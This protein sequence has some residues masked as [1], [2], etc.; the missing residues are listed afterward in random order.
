MSP[1]FSAELIAALANRVR[2][3]NEA[4]PNNR[5]KLTDLKKRFSH[6]YHG[7]SEDER[8]AAAWANVD[9]HLGKLA[10]VF[11]E[12]KH[13]RGKGGKFSGSKAPIAMA[14]PTTTAAHRRLQRTNP[15]YAALTSDIVPEGRNEVRGFWLRNALGTAAGA[16]LVLPLIRRGAG[17][18]AGTKIIQAGKLLGR[19]SVSIPAA[20]VTY[21]AAGAAERVVRPIARA[22]GKP[23][24]PGSF[25]RAAGVFTRGVGSVGEKAGHGLGW[26]AAHGAHIILQGIDHAAGDHPNPVV[27]RLR[28]AGVRAG[29]SF[30]AGA[31]LTAPM[32]GTPLDPEQ[33]GAG[34]DAF[35][36]RTIQKLA[37]GDGVADL[38]AKYAPSD[39][40]QKRGFYAQI[41][42]RLFPAAA[43]TA[44]GLGAA[45]AAEGAHA[46]LGTRHGDPYRDSRGR[47]ASRAN[48]VTVGAGIAGA[49][50]GGA[51][52]YLALKHG[53]IRALSQAVQRSAGRVDQKLAVARSDLGTGHVADMIAEHRALE[54]KLKTGRPAA[55]AEHMA[56]DPE[57]LA[58]ARRL[59]L[60]AGSHDQH[61]KEQLRREVNGRLANTLSQINEFR[62]PGPGKP[63]QWPTI[64]QVRAQAGGA[65]GKADQVARDAVLKAVD[66]ASP[67]EFESAIAEMTPTQQETARHWMRTR[68]TSIDAVDDQLAAH[69]KKLE[70]LDGKVK[71]AETGLETA[72]RGVSDAKAVLDRAGN[73]AE[74]AAAGGAYTKAQEAETAAAGAV[75]KVQK[76]LDTH[77]AKPS[78]V[79]SPVTGQPVPPATQ[80]EL[81]PLHIKARNEAEGRAGKK[82][83]ASIKKQLGASK[84]TVEAARAKQIA[85]F[86]GRGHRL[87]AAQA[88]LGR[89]NNVIPEH[90]VGASKRVIV[91]ARM[92][93]D[94]HDRE[95]DALRHV[96]LSRQLL[97]SLK[98]AQR[99]KIPKGLNAEEAAALVLK[100]HLVGGEVAGAEAYHRIA[101]A[102]AALAE[103]RLGKHAVAFRDRIM[104]QPEAKPGRMPKL[105]YRALL[106]DVDRASAGGRD[107]VHAFLRS[108]VGNAIRHVA[109]AGAEHVG[110][111]ADSVYHAGRDVARALTMRETA[112]GSGKYVIDPKKLL[113]GSPLAYVAGEA[114]RD[115][116]RYGRDQVAHQLGYDKGEPRSKFPRTIKIEKHVDPKTGGGFVGLSVPDPDGDKNERVLLWG[117]HYKDAMAAG[118]PLHIGARVSAVRSKVQEQQGKGDGGGGNR[119]AQVGDIP[120]LSQDTKN[121]VRG[122][123]NELRDRSHTIQV[124]EGHQVRFRP[125]GDS[126]KDKIG[127][128]VQQHIEKQ[129][130]ANGSPSNAERYYGALGSIV[131]SYQSPILKTKQAY[132]LLTGYAT[133]GQKANHAGVFHTGK[134]SDF[135]EQNA[136]QAQVKDELHA[137]V[138]RVMSAHPPRDDTQRTNLVRA[139]ALVGKQKGVADSDLKDLYTKIRG[140]APVGGDTPPEPA[141]KRLFPESIGVDANG[142]KAPWD[143][144]ALRET[145]IGP[146]NSLAMTLRMDN[147][148]DPT[149]IAT[150]LEAYAHIL[151]RTHGLPMKESVRAASNAIHDI[152]R[153]GSKQSAREAIKNVD[154]SHFASVLD[155]HAGKEL[156]DLERRRGVQKLHIDDL[157]AMVKG[158]L[159][160]A[161]DAIT[162]EARIPGGEDGGGEWTGGGSAGARLAREGVEEG[163][164]R[165]SRPKENTGP[166]TASNY[167]PT[168]VASDAGGFIVGEAGAYG[169]GQLVSNVLSRFFPEEAGG[170]KLIGAVR[171]AFSSGGLPAAA[172]TV[173]AQGAKA[174][175]K[176]LGSSVGG[177]T[178]FA[179]GSVVGQGAARA[180]YRVGG[181]KAPPNAPPQLSTGEQ[182]VE[183]LG[184][185]A[186]GIIGGGLG[187]GAGGVGT[188]AA[189]AVGGYA[190]GAIGRNIYDAASSISQYFDGHDSGQAGRALNR[191]LTPRAAPAGAAAPQTPTKQP[192]PP[193]QPQGDPGIPP[194]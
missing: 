28:H 55:I 4:T 36:Y 139:V 94:A 63:S 20:T 156:D 142:S 7:A 168:R 44:A 35:S 42:R 72:K 97:A 134:D 194:I 50:A 52:A 58:E 184:S 157:P 183:T 56:K 91:A 12:G 120:G 84:A 79:I 10:K 59:A 51:A 33:I 162:N 112:E 115:A 89:R 174:G 131:G 189:G 54:A 37:G 49:L 100:G 155:A 187:A 106:R 171:N 126:S 95:V 83:D 14:L 57:Y 128:E 130:L 136:T 85:K 178:G 74:H 19:Y 177:I 8:T 2:E 147:R 160:D 143:K 114:A 110:H 124:E 135:A 149:D 26:G 23:I 123:V 137:E 133:G 169:A 164:T 132:R 127:D 5:V 145:S 1:K 96:I 121:A 101:V 151:H 192:Q 32:V 167:N 150:A 179:A 103:R 102:H 108:P 122:A 15:A 24:E 87:L 161:V 173:A 185:I 27:A 60:Y 186:G 190:G 166:A 93:E 175:A 129:F 90:A 66:G 76:A 98:E 86:E 67:Q 165:L 107:A 61:I 193:S 3:H 117:E 16:A 119:N 43:A 104:A 6:G 113:V 176:A 17:S 118:D 116:Y 109:Q 92:L 105:V 170:I 80:A 18:G 148:N 78:G 158:L 48:A 46:V 73:D 125:N 68:Q 154:V 47:F 141:T 163:V 71:E 22:V 146:A 69:N 9:R 82:V 191:A 180:A 159:G 13:P 21:P 30:G 31:A 53:N 182:V 62:V 64:G 75:T 34:V 152:A 70:T 39:T 99:G 144:R 65:V 77:R 81:Q 111:A 153:N 181:G 40:L 172:G 38:L 41:A 138:D 188:I 140:G 29:L 25:Y 88:L 45:G 11:D